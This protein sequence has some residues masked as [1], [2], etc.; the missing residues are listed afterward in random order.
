RKY[1]IEVEKQANQ[2]QKATPMLALKQT[3]EVLENHDERLDSLE[4]FKQ[5]Y[6][7]NRPIDGEMPLAL[8]KARKRRVMEIV[9]GKGTK[10]YE[11]FYTDILRNKV[12]RDY[13]DR[14]MVARYRD[15]KV[16]DFHDALAFLEDWEPSKETRYA[17]EYANMQTTLDV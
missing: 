8:E 7:E 14:F 9:G 12:F 13:S 10:A 5:D 3:F 16:K 1:F 15:T 2:P 17:V 11:E 6:E 4:E